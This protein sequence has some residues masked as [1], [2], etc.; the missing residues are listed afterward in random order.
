MDPDNKLLWRANRN[1]LEVEAIRD[2]ILLI[3]GKLDVTRPV[4]SPIT[5]WA[6]A[7]KKPRF[8]RII[9]RAPDFAPR[10]LARCVRALRSRLARAP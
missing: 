5:E 2:S 9:S 4:E 7:A 8:R 3:S 1:R 6:G 10:V